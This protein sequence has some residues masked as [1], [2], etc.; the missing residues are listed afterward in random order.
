MNAQNLVTTPPSNTAVVVTSA[1]CPEC[2][3]G[4]AFR[5]EF[6]ASWSI[7]RRSGPR[8]AKAPA[9]KTCPVTETPTV[10]LYCGTARPSAPSLSG[11]PGT[12]AIL[13]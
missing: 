12:G 6:N 8:F 1:V 13:F 2:L 3:D 5:S 7:G 9:S 4:N 10:S 11:Y